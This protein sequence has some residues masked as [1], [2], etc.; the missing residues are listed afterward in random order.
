M[1]RMGHMGPME[2]GRYKLSQV[3]LVPYVPSVPLMSG[4]TMTRLPGTLVNGRGGMVS[5][6]F[7][8]RR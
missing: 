2:G 1:G 6:H 3:P 5:V 4:W 7:N 8:E